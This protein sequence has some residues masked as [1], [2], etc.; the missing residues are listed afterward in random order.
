MVRVT[1]RLFGGFEAR[2]SSGATLVLA[3]KK[4]QALLAYL[5]S[6]PG[7]PHPRDKLASLLWGE[8]SDDQA[9][10]GLRH[11]LAALRR[12]LG[13]ADGVLRSEGQA[14]VVDAAGVEADVAAFERQIADG[15]P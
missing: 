5:G 12:A 8:K 11:A 13:D 7:Q 2:F 3:T 15:T 10:D 14:L 6:H 9:R 4:A 1:V